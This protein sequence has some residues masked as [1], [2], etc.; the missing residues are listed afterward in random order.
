MSD[1]GDD[2]RAFKGYKRERKQQNYINVKPEQKL[3]DAGIFYESHN[4][5]LHLIIQVNESKIDFWP[6]TGKWSVR[7]GIEG[8]GVKALINFVKAAA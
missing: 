2:F 4:N 7:K 3:K 6:T 5:G 8:F 1:L